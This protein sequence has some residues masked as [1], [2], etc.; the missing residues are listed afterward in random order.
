MESNNTASSDKAGETYPDQYETRGN[1]IWEQDPKGQWSRVEDVAARLDHQANSVA[2]LAMM[3]AVANERAET[4]KSELTAA[5][6]TIARL[7][8]ERDEAQR[9]ERDCRQIITTYCEEIDGLTAKIQRL[10]AGA[11]NM[12]ES[13]HELIMAVARKF[14][15]ET[16]HQTALRYIL[17]AE[18]R[19]NETNGT[20]EALSETVGDGGESGK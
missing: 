13:Y 6:A 16:R 17:S 12:S 1:E 14:S 4:L 5:Q 7:E 11:V 15:D 9:S 20:K 3:Y 10:E 18:T 8:G 19:S 2:E